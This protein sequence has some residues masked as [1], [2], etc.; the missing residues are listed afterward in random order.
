MKRQFGLLRSFLPLYL[1]TCVDKLWTRN[2][3]HQPDN[4][5]CLLFSGERKSLD[6]VD[7]LTPSDIRI[8][9]L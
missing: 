8:S 4:K 1:V 7:Y 9:W 2:E 3:Q 5:M 6:D